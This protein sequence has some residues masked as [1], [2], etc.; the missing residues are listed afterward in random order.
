MLLWLLSGPGLSFVKMIGRFVPKDWPCLWALCGGARGFYYAP[1]VWRVW[2]ASMVA[3]VYAPV[4]AAR[5]NT[6]MAW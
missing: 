5:L 4:C 6:S 2:I 1:S 3:S